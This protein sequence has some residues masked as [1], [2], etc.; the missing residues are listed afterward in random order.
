MATKIPQAERIAK[1]VYIEQH[2]DFEK[3]LEEVLEGFSQKV[4]SVEYLV[5]FA[6]YISIDVD[7]K[8]KV[9]GTPLFA[10]KVRIVL[11]NAG[12]KNIKITSKVNCAPH[13]PIKVNSPFY[14]L[15]VHKKNAWIKTPLGF[16]LWAGSV[17][18]PIVDILS[19]DKTISDA[20]QYKKDMKSYQQKVVTYKNTR[21]T[22]EFQL[23]QLESI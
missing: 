21:V 11:E 16:V 19:L 18:L 10:H 17:V 3:I 23:P 6:Q 7:D 20:K 22:I 15:C 1:R 14:D 2:C 9:T 12:Y 5:N 13:K 4:N 8:F